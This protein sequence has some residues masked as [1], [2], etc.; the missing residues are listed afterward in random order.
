MRIHRTGVRIEAYQARANVD[1]VFWHE[2]DQRV[3]FSCN[4]D[5]QF[6]YKKCARVSPP[7]LLAFFLSSL[8]VLPSLLVVAMVADVVH[9]RRV[10]N[11][12]FDAF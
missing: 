7:T 6:R 11:P 12:W 3:H 4:R 10:H 1:N 2:E 8:T 5:G 9:K